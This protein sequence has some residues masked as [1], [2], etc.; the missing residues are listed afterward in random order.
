M[1]IFTKSIVLLFSVS[2]LVALLPV[3]AHG[4]AVIHPANDIRSI[5]PDVV[6]PP[7]VHAL[8]APGTRVRETHPDYRRTDVYHATYLPTDWKPSGRYPVIIEFAGNGP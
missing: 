4:Q 6:L 8:P 1:T 7:M 5:A 2:S 3:Y